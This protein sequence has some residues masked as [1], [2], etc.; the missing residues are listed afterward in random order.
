MPWWPVCDGKA[1][2]TF[3]RRVTQVRNAEVSATRAIWPPPP[4]GSVSHSEPLSAV[5]SSGSLPA[6]GSEYTDSVPDVA[7]LPTLPDPAVNH[8]SLVHGLGAIEVPG[9]PVL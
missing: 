1:K 9:A 2:V 8:R 4:L 5:M 3:G 6:V 7:I